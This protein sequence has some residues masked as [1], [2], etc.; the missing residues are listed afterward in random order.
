[1]TRPRRYPERLPNPNPTC[2]F[3]DILLGSD[4]LLV[5]ILDKDAAAVL[6]EG[7]SK[8]SRLPRSLISTASAMVSNIPVTRMESLDRTYG[9]KDCDFVIPWQRQTVGVVA[10]DIGGKRASVD[11][12]CARAERVAFA[13]VAALRDR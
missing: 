13:V 7:K 11:Q 3:D 12:L 1:M 4:F 5:F 6:E 8:A 2:K 9:H 10:S